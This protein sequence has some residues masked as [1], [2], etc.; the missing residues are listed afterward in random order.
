MKP[1]FHAASVYF[2][3]GDPICTYVALSRSQI[4]GADGAGKKAEEAA[5]KAADYDD[6]MSDDDVPAM[7]AGMSFTYR[8]K[9]LFTAA[10]LKEHRHALRSGE[11]IAL[12]R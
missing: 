8:A 9:D 1:L 4:V 11:V 12:Y 5:E 6:M 10:E 2:P 7:Q 3:Y